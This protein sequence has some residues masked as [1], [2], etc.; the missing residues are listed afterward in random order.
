MLN[1]SVKE[2]VTAMLNAKR[3]IS[4]GIFPLVLPK[5]M[6][7]YNEEYRHSREAPEHATVR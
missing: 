7:N 6:L 5:L 3:K 4:A 1:A 2:Y